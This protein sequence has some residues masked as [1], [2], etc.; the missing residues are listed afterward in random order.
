MTYNVLMGMLNP[1]HSLTHPSVR[2]VVW[3]NVTVIVTLC[4]SKAA[5]Q[6][7][8]IV[9]VCGFVGLLPR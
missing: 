9:P 7:I 4:A 6:C 5:A 2:N 8:V 1:V 3:F